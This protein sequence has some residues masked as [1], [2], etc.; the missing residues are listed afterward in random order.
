MDAGVFA[1]NKK[2][3]WVIQML[4]TPL[5]EGVDQHSLAGPRV[6]SRHIY[7]YAYDIHIHMRYTCYIL[8]YM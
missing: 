5:P 4:T 3:L 1:K 6:E 2:M 8:I 7:T